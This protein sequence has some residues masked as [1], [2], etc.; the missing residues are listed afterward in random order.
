M[1]T[2]KFSGSQPAPL[3]A[4]FDSVSLRT[5]DAVAFADLAHFIS[6]CVR[7]ECVKLA[8]LRLGE[9]GIAVFTAT[10]HNLSG[11]CGKMFFPVSPQD[12]VVQVAAQAVRTSA[13]IAK[14]FSYSLIMAFVIQVCA[15]WFRTIFKLPKCYVSKFR[16]LADLGPAVTFW[17][18]TA[19]PWMAC[20]RTAGT[21]NVRFK[22]RSV[23]SSFHKDNYSHFPVVR[24]GD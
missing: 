13:W 4:A 15:W 7:E 11:R 2:Q 22:P 10:A 8:C 19:C 20:V 21:V 24:G 5:A 1:P 18:P 17:V 6:F 23:V 16:L 14:T 12:N 3:L 9:S